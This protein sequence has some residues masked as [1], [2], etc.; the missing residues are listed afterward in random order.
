VRTAA[1]RDALRDAGIPALELDLALDELGVLPL[2]GRRVFH[3][4]PPPGQGTEDWVTRRLI[5]AFAHHG[6]P[7]RIVYISTTGVYGDCGGAWVDETWP[8]RP[9]AE[10]ARRRVDAEQRLR[11]WSRTPGASLVT[12]RVAGIYGPGRLPVERIR[13]GLPLVR[14]SEAPYSNRIHVADLVQVC[15]AAMERGLDGA[16][17]NACDDEPTTMTDYFFQVAD[18]LGLPRPPVIPLAEGE[19]QLSPGMLSY[20]QE[21]RRLSNR[22]LRDE[23]GLALAFPT[24]REGLAASL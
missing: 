11:E 18:A 13:Q 5:A 23:L 6:H 4:A 24:L 17:Y 21:S 19:G 1:S 20:M 10:R 12:L 14:E 9:S 22:R 16:V 8:T 3:L 15:I 2:T 7:R